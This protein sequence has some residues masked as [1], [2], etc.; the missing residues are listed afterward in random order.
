MPSFAAEAQLSPDKKFLYLL[1]SAHIQRAIEG[2]DD[3][4]CSIYKIRLRTRP[5]DVLLTQDGDIEPS[6]LIP[7]YRSDYGRGAMDF[8]PTVLQ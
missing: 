8:L 5:L 1:T 3:E 6:L 7:N 4:R 2:L